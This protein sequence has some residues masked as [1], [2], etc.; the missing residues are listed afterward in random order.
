MR[1]LQNKR[2]LLIMP[3]FFGY[4]AEIKTEL[5]RWGAIVDWLPDRPFDGPLMAAA[6]K[7][8]PTWVSAV[9]DRFYDRLLKQFSSS[10]YDLILV[11][12]GQTLSARTLS[13]LRCD[14]PTAEI[15]L[16]LWDSIEN[17]RH[18]KDRLSFY[19]KV[20]TFDPT[21]AEKFG[22]RLRPLFYS[23][24]FDLGSSPSTDLSYHISFIGTS[25]S[26][27]YP[28]IRRLRERLPKHLSSFWY[29]YLQA[30]WVLNYYR[31]TNSEM[32]QAPTSDFHFTPMSKLN[33]QS[34]F[35]STRVILDIEH[36]GQRGLTMRTFEALGSGKKLVT[37][38]PLIEGYDFFLPENIIVVNR[39]LPIVPAAFFDS[40]PKN[41]SQ[42]I[43]N[44]Y[45]ITGWLNEIIGCSIDEAAL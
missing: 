16:Y 20:F 7:I 26:D 28:V 1:R 11:V 45:S 34:V 5:I 38:N 22:L 35:L 24:G 18:L 19:D 12:N 36:P 42:T 15:I 41:V 37:T 4:E 13:R 2:V 9:A 3:R 25:H 43:R 32:R 6:T 39:A 33:T 21:D 44:R 31:L 14:F 27:R 29:L 40:P 30:H 8:R 10:R 23:R 17:R